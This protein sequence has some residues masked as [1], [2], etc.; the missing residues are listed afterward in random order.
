MTKWL[1]G[2]CV[3]CV[4]VLSWQIVDA[5][6]EQDKTAVGVVVMAVGET[7]H[8]ANDKVY[9]GDALRTGA[10][11]SLMVS[12]A[13]NAKIALRA[14]TL[15][16]IENYNYAPN[17]PAE[18]RVKYLLSYGTLRSITGEA[19][20]QN[21]AG[22][23]LN[24][25]LAAIGVRG[26]DFIT[27]ATD[28]TLKVA[29][30]SGGVSVAPYSQ[31]CTAGGFGA[32]EVSNKLEAAANTKVNAVELIK[33][34]TS[35]EMHPT[36]WLPEAVK[37]FQNKQS[38]NAAPQD[39]ASIGAVQ[40]ASSDQVASQH[41][42]QAKIQ[43]NP[44]MWGRWEGLMTND[45]SLVSAATLQQAQYQQVAA[46]QSLGMFV[47]PAYTLGGLPAEGRVQLAPAQAQVYWQQGNQL[48]KGEFDSG[49]L[50]LN[51]SN[52]TFETYL[53]AKA[54]PQSLVSMM[55]AKGDILK[56]GAFLSDATA[57]N[58]SVTGMIGEQGRSAGMLFEQQQANGK[59]VGGVSWRP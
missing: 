38:T 29:V 27:Q 34:D 23:R 53:Y 25:P 22:F 35:I 58:V 5:A 8:H 47:S 6:T 45:K 57:S 28:N 40:Q 59:L 9:V 24:T 49:V 3:S 30:V 4:A 20:H 15:V 52:K 19:G 13:D 41:L 18:N 44:I 39:T 31:Q 10:G 26:T 12:F 42:E 36:D 1:A 2:L 11:A 51:F 54:T 50:G 56:D 46:T 16:R 48:T 55:H 7:S 17:A 14:D 33:R 21:K 37:Q 43:T 32:C